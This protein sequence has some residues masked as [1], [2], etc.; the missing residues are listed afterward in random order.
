MTTRTL[1]VTLEKWPL[2]Q[3]FRITGHTF[4]DLDLVVVTLRQD[5]FIGRGEAAGVYYLHDDA[6]A[7]VKQIEAAR[8]AIETG[9][10]RP[11]L[12]NLLPAG[13]ARN[14]VDCALWE[15]QAKR[16]GRAVWQIAGL[17][18]PK[19]LLTTYTLGAD[20]P[21]SM[22][23]AAVAFV[24]ARALKLKL[25]GEPADEDRVCAV[26]EAR[27]EVWLA[28]DA[29]QGYTRSL[30]E[31]VLPV[32]VSAGVQLIEQP[33]PRGE[34]TQLSNLQSPIPIAADESVQSSSDL[35]RFADLFD[36]V[37]I[38]LD[39][40]GGL[41]EGL[42]MARRAREF[43]LDVMVGNM[44]G[45]SLAMA[46]GFLLGQLCTVVDLDGPLLMA[47]DRSP[48]VRYEQ[49]ELWCPEEVWGGS[50]A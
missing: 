35:D 33:L 10:E 37:N 16:S 48:S 26:R 42:A 36:V 21:E 11:A 29:N 23:A 50:V 34:E 17:D 4:T 7:I 39:K 15:L 47:S 46:P 18:P 24:E 20:T 3:P 40:C 31:R 27:P 49:G 28:I 1:H 43:G 25:T 30:L 12:Q 5:G 14:A 13:G 9:V 32:F 19:P 2:K 8:V 44:A 41:T 6:A 38:K 45:T 22:A